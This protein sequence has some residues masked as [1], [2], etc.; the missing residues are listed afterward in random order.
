[1]V[2][3]RH[4]TLSFD[5]DGAVSTFDSIPFWMNHNT[6][7]KYAQNNFGYAEV[8]F[9]SL[10][11][12]NKKLKY[13][14]G[15]NFG[16]NYSFDNS[17][18]QF[19]DLYGTISY[20]SIAIDLGIK[21]DT[22][23]FENL[24]SSNG[25][26]VKSNNSRAFPGINLYLKNYV[27]FFFWKSWFSWKFNYGE[28]LLDDPRYVENTHVHSKSLWLNFKIK[29]RARFE[30]GLE[31]W[32]QW[33][34]NSPRF[35]D[36][37]Y[38]FS[39]YLR[40]VFL[41]K[42]GEDA[43]ETDQVNRAGNH[44]GN[45]QFN[46]YQTYSNFDMMLYHSHPF[47]DG[48]GMGFANFPDGIWGVNFNLNNNQLFKKI[49]FEW[50]YTKDVTNE[51][52]HDI[53]GGQDKYFW[54]AVYR[55]GWFYFGQSIGTPFIQPNINEDGIV[56]DPQIQYNRFSALHFGLSGG[57]PKKLN[58]KTKFSYVKYFPWI[59][60]SYSGKVNQFSGYAEVDLAPWLD[61][62]GEIAFGGAFDLG[63]RYSQNLGGFIKLSYQAGF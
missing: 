21:R 41:Q 61:W 11:E 4:N 20:A 47:E 9:T 56:L 51:G 55:S 32:A 62:S 39:D 28:Y 13:H 10:D 42:G 54:N 2:G 53:T 50:I 43:L 36:M 46:F 40:M 16:Y 23:L 1:M 8:G 15:V 14:F 26:F 34:G 22:E 49:L 37:D 60:E 18:Y 45:F 33:G 24:S 6:Y 3:Q 29:S 57:L 19:N 59:G 44:I 5:L 63:N 58:Y 52:Q 7:G 25:N 12:S 30:L 31:D 38:S 27:P 17:E 48:S 35:G